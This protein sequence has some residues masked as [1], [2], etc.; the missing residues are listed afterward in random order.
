[1]PHGRMYVKAYCMSEMKKYPSAMS[2]AA[3]RIFFRNVCNEILA[4][5]RPVKKAELP[6]CILQLLRVLCILI[7]ALL[8]HK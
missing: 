2:T 1:M 5:Q 6:K 3:E 8:L 4:S 7:T